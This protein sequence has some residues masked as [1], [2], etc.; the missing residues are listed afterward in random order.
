MSKGVN[1]RSFRWFSGIAIAIAFGFTDARADIYVRDKAGGENYN[2]TPNGVFYSGTSGIIKAKFDGVNYRDQPL[3]MFDFQSN[4]G[5]GWIDFATYCIDPFQYLSIAGPTANPGTPHT[6][7]SLHGYAA[8]NDNEEDWIETL[9]ANAFEDSKTSQKKSSAF[10]S[11]LWE[12]AID[13]T[14]NLGSGTFQVKN[15]GYSGEVI[16]QANAWMN[17]ILTGV[18]TDSQDLHVYSSPYT[19]DLLVP[20]PAPGAAIL[21]LIGFATYHMLKKRFA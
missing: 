15:S 18:W 4:D 17:N 12:L 20:V 9:W 16:T 8:I 3:G 11:I 14:F 10:Q 7:V 2:G 19:Q 21:G 1:S 6:E 13:D 5:T